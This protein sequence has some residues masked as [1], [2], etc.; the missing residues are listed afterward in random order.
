MNDDRDWWVKPLRRPSALK[1]GDRVAV[2]SPSWGGPSVFPHRYDAGRRYVE[3]TFG[4][5]LVEMPHALSPAQW[6]AANPEA[7]AADLMEA[8]GDPTIA[9]ILTSIGGDDAIRLLPY[10]DLAVIRDNPKVFVGYSDPTVI[11]FACLKAGV[12]SFYGPGIMSGF[13]ENSGM[14]ASGRESFR[15]AVF[16]AR[17]PGVLAAPSEGWTSE[18]LDWSD[19]ANQQR[20]RA[21]TPASGPRCLQGTIIVSGPLIGGCADVMEVLKATA[22]WPPITYWNGA[23]LFLETSEE[24]PSAH[25]VARWLRNYAAQGILARISALLLGRWGGQIDDEERARLDA[26][27][28][29]VLADEGL[30]HLPVLVDLD[31]GHTDPILTLAYGAEASVDCAAATVE[32]VEAGVI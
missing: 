21:R 6:L 3:D 31:I 32:V 30:Q 12:G 1:P 20:P 27:V 4:L 17:A 2:V 19:P 8:F 26:V 28:L 9:G 23:V 14:T 13:A 18:L 11:H 29:G 5:E 7:R 25:L 15:S 24:G 10:L 22:W 16:E